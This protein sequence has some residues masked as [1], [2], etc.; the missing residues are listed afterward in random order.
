M[1]KE[2]FKDPIGL[3]T[4]ISMCALCG[5]VAMILFISTPF[6]EPSGVGWILGSMMLGFAFLLF[7][8]MVAIGKHP[9][10][11]KISVSCD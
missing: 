4:I 9:M 6:V 2:F 5:F 8:G 3:A 7:I 11:S 10:V 1:K